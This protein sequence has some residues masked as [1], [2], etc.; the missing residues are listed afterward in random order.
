MVVWPIVNGEYVGSSPGGAA[1]E[2]FQLCQR[3]S[4]FVKI[5]Q[6]SSIFIETFSTIKSVGNFVR[7]HD[8]VFLLHPFRVSNFSINFIY[9]V[10]IYFSDQ[11]SCLCVSRSSK[12][13]L[14]L[15]FETQFS[16]FKTFTKEKLLSNITFHFF[17][18]HKWLKL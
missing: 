4:T 10:V 5:C 9:S 17:A 11:I 8:I 12:N 13:F 6:T 3:S 14:P 18:T 2:T 15:P 16:L 1:F 7:H